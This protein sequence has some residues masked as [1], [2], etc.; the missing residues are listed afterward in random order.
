MNGIV[1]ISYT[2]TEDPNALKRKFDIVVFGVIGTTLES[3]QFSNQSM[4][5]FVSWFDL[6]SSSKFQILIYK[7]SFD[8]CRLHMLS[9]E[10]ITCVSPMHVNVKV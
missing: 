3:T 8:L 7:I 1:N 2:K 4:L 6:F 9:C 10:G 5:V